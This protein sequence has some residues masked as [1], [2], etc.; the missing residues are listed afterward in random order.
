MYMFDLNDVLFCIKSLKSPEPCL[1]SLTT[2]NSI[3]KTRDQQ[4]VASFN[5]FT[6]QTIKL[7]NFILRD[8]LEFE[9]P[10][11]LLIYHCQF[12]QLEQNYI[13]SYRHIL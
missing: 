1:T 13:N 12:P 4:L 7:E 9:M 2:F 3:P 8:F 10:Y 6:L 5:I 11:L